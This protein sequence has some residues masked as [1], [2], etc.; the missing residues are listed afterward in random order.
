MDRQRPS[1]WPHNLSSND[2]G[3]G[4]S[5]SIYNGIGTSGLSIWKSAG[6]RLIARRVHESCRHKVL[7]WRIGATALH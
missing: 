4:L 1:M 5:S 7:I 2:G 3:C 6:N